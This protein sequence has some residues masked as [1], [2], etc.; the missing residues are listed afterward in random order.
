MALEILTSEY[1]N[2]QESQEIACICAE[3]DDFDAFGDT[4]VFRFFLPYIM[5]K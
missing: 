4:Q 3:C 5:A 1:L 2:E